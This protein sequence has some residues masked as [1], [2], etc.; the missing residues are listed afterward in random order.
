[1]K[2]GSCSWP[3]SEATM[4]ELCLV[5]RS[6]TKQEASDVLREFMFAMTVPDF[7][8]SVSVP[9]KV[10]SCKPFWR[11]WFLSRIGFVYLEKSFDGHVNK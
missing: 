3:P 2:R 10:K 5:C 8:P 4:G 1:M 6:L 7:H 9:K 11:G